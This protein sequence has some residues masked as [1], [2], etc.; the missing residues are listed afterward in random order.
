MLDFTVGYDKEVIV[1]PEETSVVPCRGDC[2]FDVLEQAAIVA[3]PD[4]NVIVGGCR[5][6]DC[7][8]E[9]TWLLSL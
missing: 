2:Y 8:V 4:S 6:S 9:N 3:V 1:E 7:L 5:V